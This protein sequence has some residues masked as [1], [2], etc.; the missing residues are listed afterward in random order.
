V[1]EIKM[2]ASF[3]RESPEGR[4]HYEDLSTDGRIILKLV[5][6]VLKSAF[7]LIIVVI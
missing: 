6:V 5:L 1:E 2:R 4:D 7:G 3:I